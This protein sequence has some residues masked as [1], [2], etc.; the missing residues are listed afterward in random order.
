MR[1]ANMAVTWTP[2]IKVLDFEKN[3][4]KFTATRFDDVTGESLT[5]SNT[6]IISTAQDKQDAEANI[7]SQYNEVIQKRTNEQIKGENW[8][9]AAAINLKNMEA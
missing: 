6:S 7:I 1:G 9:N 5:F 4:I 2:T 3:L 8:L